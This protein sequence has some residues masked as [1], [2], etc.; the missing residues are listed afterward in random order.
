MLAAFN[1]FFV[2]WECVRLAKGCFDWCALDAANDSP[3]PRLLAMPLATRDRG[4]RRMSLA[5]NAG[6]NKPAKRCEHLN[7][8]GHLQVEN[9]LPVFDVA[10][11]RA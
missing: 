9:A 5:L 3:A 2:V 10:L 8:L 1:R 4:E 11:T 7:G 6:S